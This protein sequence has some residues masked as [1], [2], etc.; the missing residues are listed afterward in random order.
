[1][2]HPTIAISRAAGSPNGTIDRRRVT[3]ARWPAT[4]GCGRLRG[5]R[6]GG[7]SGPP[8]SRSAWARSFR[9]GLRRGASE[10][11]DSSARAGPFH[12]ERGITRIRSSAAF[13]CQLALCDAVVCC[14]F[15]GVEG[16]GIGSRP[17]RAFNPARF[18]RTCSNP[19]AS[20][21]QKAAKTNAAHGAVGSPRT[22]ATKGQ[23]G[24]CGALAFDGRVQQ[25]GAA[26]PSTQPK[27]SRAQAAGATGT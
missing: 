10:S 18:V 15:P 2:G 3:K 17:F 6:S 27:R 8:G 16:H 13:K 1:V 26:A 21:R 14:M 5:R 9:R 4:A 12:R 11:K 22:R 23:S 25:R 19:S 20:F 24:D 7:S